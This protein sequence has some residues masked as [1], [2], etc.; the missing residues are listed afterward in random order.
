MFSSIFNRR[1]FYCLA[2]DCIVNVFIYSFLDVAGGGQER[3]ESLS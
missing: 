3:F 1:L 2:I